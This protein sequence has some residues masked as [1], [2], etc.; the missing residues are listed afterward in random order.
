MLLGTWRSG[1]GT[2]KGNADVMV[3][4][5]GQNQGTLLEELGVIFVTKD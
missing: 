4:F 1:L 3:T 2:M 5:I